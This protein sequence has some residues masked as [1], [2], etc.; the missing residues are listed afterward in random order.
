MGRIFADTC[1]L[2]KIYRVETNSPQVRAC[3][4]S[5]DVIL[6]AHA[7]LLEFPSAFYGMVRQQRL[8]L[9][10][11]SIYINAF[12]TD[13]QQYEML[14]SDADV[15]SEAKHLLDCYA[16]T[17]NLRPMDA[18]QLATALVE[19]RNTH[20]DTFVTTDRV[21]ITVALAEGLTVKP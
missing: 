16:V 6:I 7:S 9:Q 15:Y 10:E 17:H 12:C 19:H 4:A 3:F 11:A 18:L 1:A 20:L 14:P 5:Q 13:I 8:T 21:L 2:V